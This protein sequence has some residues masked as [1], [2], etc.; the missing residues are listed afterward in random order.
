MNR[1]LSWIESFAYLAAIALAAFLRFSGLNI[2]SL[3]GFEAGWALQAYQVATNSIVQLGPNPGY[4]AFSA[5]LMFFFG[6][7]TAVARLAPA[8]AGVSLVIIPFVLRERFGRTAA[9]ILAFGLAIDPFLVAFAR[10]AGGPMLA[11]A[12]G[13]WALVFFWRR[14]SAPA[15]IFT[16]LSLL[17]GVYIW[18][19]ALTLGVA[20]LL[21]RILPGGKVFNGAQR[22]DRGG[23]QVFGALMVGT[24]L[25]VGTFLTLIPQGLGAF[26]GIFP[27]YLRTW[28]QSSGIP[29]W[30]NPLALL[31]YQ[32]LVLVFGLF[33]GIRSVRSGEPLDR[34]A[35]LWAVFA[36]LLAVVLPGRLPLDLIWVVLPLW[37][38]ASRTLA[39]FFQM[40]AEAPFAVLL[41]AL[42]I[43]V[44]MLVGW[45]NIAGFVVDGQVLRLYFTLGLLAIALVATYLI[46][47][48]WSR[49]AAV[50]GLVWGLCLGLLLWIGSEALAPGR[51]RTG[52]PV[53]LWQVP[54]AA[55]EI[56]LALRTLGDFSEWKTGRRDALEMEVVGIDPTVQWYL[57]NFPNAI[58]RQAS[59]PNE[60]PLVLITPAEY[61]DPQLSLPYRGQDVSWSYRASWANLPLRDWLRWLFYRQA[62]IED[63]LITIWARADIFPGGEALPPST[64]PL[65]VPEDDQLPEESPLR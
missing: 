53:E 8:L 39:H 60:L 62:P 15:G 37:W 21:L 58:Y 2:L 27:A 5:A 36:F 11:V 50:T 64:A 10:L 47:A 13:L 44:L 65:S 32:P 48:G 35:A 6:D 31:V 54:P 63:Q 46:A 12:F 51:P 29:V 45:L 9:V 4:A 1:S 25:F 20:Y 24:V 41:E 34:L 17:S 18:Q 57:R 28:W 55:G 40:P 61:P 42:I 23:W 14:Q 43:F 19:G 16:G 30:Q 49:S 33:G 59:V 26:A 56:N 7:S 38:L 3:D 22:F 52:S